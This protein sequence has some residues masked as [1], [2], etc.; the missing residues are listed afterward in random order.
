MLIVI[1]R[2]VSSYRLDTPRY[3]GPCCCF[4][5]S[6]WPR[7]NLSFCIFD[8]S[9]DFGPETTVVIFALRLFSDSVGRERGFDIH[10]SIG[11]GL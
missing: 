8:I 2:H 7:L 3:A 1:R 4:V 9:L 6:S 11:H 5:K 10:N